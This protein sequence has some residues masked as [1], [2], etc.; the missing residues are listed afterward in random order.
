MPIKAVLFDFMGTC[1]DWHSAIIAALPQSLPHETRSQ[2][3]LTWRQA[4]F[5]HNAALLASGQPPEDIDTSHRTTLAS[6]LASSSPQ[7]Q[8]AFAETPGAEDACVAAWHNQ[9]AWPDVAPAIEKLRSSFTVKETGAVAGRHLDVLVHANG[10]LRLQL[11][12]CRSSGLRFD[13]LLSSELLGVYK[14]APESYRRA[15][16]LLRC[17]ADECVMVAAHA[18]DTRGAKAVGMKTVYVYR[19]TDDIREDQA[20][21]RRE[22]DAYL[23]SMDELAETIA[24]LSYS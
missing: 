4:Y 17:E 18:Y 13:S 2:F 12:L 9:P 21:V 5:D 15:L 24:R 16:E 6:Q 8:T 22:N 3:A 19:W 10:T 14:P 23:E 7:V 1:L 20:A 11:D